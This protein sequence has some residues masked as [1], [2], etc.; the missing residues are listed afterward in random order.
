MNIGFEAKRLFQN[1]SGLGN[2]GRNIINLLDRYY[3]D[4]KY[5]LFTPKISNLYSV[6]DSSSVISPKSLF[7]KYF[8][9]IWRS[10]KVSKLLYD[11][12][13]DIFHGLSHSLPYGI[14]R[15]NI[16]SVVTM[17]DLIFLRYPNYYKKIDRYMYRSMYLSS[18][19]RATKIIAISQQTKID[20]INYFG[21]EPNKI[22]VIY[23]SCDPRFY[24]RV[25]EELKSS[26][27]LKFKLPDKFILCVG[28]IEQRKNQLAILKAISMGDIDATIL[29]AGS[30]TEYIGQ[31]YKFINNSGIKNKVMFLHN[32]TF[33]DL[34]V[35][36]QMAEMMVYPSLFE[37]FGLP[38]LEAQASGCPVITSNL[39]SLPEAGGKGA[40]Y[41][42]P[43]NISEINQAIVKILSNNKAREELIQKGD[44]NAK[45]FNEKNIADSL[46]KLYTELNENIR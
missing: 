29:I 21:I 35:I 46:M 31:L 39:S 24:N 23:Q 16:P 12:K 36:Y 14:E 42:D 11:N 15:T 22:T 40:L 38:V 17:H 8:N 32:A 44:V 5:I 45:L 2:Y 7:F 18:C 41:V 10:H 3:P 13:I 26:V 6:P 34:R 25:S 19:K 1:R 27:R 43:I 37:G 20:L 30:P 9:S 4:N 33:D 28:T